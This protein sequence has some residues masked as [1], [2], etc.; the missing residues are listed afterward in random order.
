MVRVATDADAPRIADIYNHYVTETTVTFEEIA[1]TADDIR[2]MAR[3]L[4]RDDLMTTV[5]V[6]KPIGLVGDP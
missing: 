4:L 6:G 2:R 5:V 1:V 3:R